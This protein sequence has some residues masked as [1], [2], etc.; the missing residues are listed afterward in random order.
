[1][2]RRAAV[3]D[4]RASQ[5]PG[6]RVLCRWHALRSPASWATIRCAHVCRKRGSSVKPQG[7]REKR[8]TGRRET[9]RHRDVDDLGSQRRGLE[10]PPRALLE[11]VR[12]R[13]ARALGAFFDHYFPAIYGLAYR[14][15]SNR[16]Q[17]E[18]A[19]QEIFLKIHR[20]ADRLDPDR[21]PAPWLLTITLNTCRSLVRS[22]AHRMSQQA[23]MANGSTDHLNALTDPGRNP[24]ETRDAAE[25]ERAV[26]EALR[27]LPDALR[28]VVI[29][30]DYQGLAHKKIAGILDLKPDAVRK[31]YSRALAELAEMLKDAS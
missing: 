17:A 16:Q 13:D 9:E 12:C 11:G 26:Q 7:D 5:I 1:M 22:G 15:L 3:E 18:D 27:R 21:D 8:S 20:G 23:V 2:P 19:S 30:R 14:F 25:S 28:E 6:R 10:P 29:L 24:E 31:R 4:L